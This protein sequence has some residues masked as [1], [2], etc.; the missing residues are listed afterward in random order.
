MTLDLDR[1]LNDVVTDPAIF[2]QPVRYTPQSG[3]S[4]VLNAIFTDAA[5]VV[6]L[7][8]GA[9]H[10]TMAPMLGVKLSDFPDGFPPQQGDTAVILATGAAYLVKDVNPD[11]GG[12]AKLPL[13]LAEKD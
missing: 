6:A 3:A 7:G 8:E 2:A 4:F 13:Q 1:L 11:G 5:T 10:S 9:D 12:M